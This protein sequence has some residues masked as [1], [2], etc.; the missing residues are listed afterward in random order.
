M[1]W[2]PRTPQDNG[3]KRE[4]EILKGLGAMAHPMSGAGRIKDDGHDDEY[5][6]EVKTAAKQFTI[7]EKDMDALWT[8]AMKAGLEPVYIVEF[9]GST[10]YLT[11]RKN[12]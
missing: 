3:R 8:R 6:Y 12:Q 11:I 2:N 10:A 5:L 4:K 7:K 1:P 9:P